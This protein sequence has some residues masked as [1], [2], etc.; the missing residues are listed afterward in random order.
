[1]S[2]VL[3]HV[4]DGAGEAHGFV[5]REVYQV[6]SQALGGAIADAGELL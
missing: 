1:V 4:A 6:E 3:F 5:V 2:K